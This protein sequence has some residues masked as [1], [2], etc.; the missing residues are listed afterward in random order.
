MAL[1][2]VADGLIR[3]IGLQLVIGKMLPGLYQIFGK[4]GNVVLNPD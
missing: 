2:L 3:V 1:L 4:V